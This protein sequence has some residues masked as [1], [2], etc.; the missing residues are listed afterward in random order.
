MLPYD[1]TWKKHRTNAT[2]VASANTSINMFDRVQEAESAHFLLNLL[3][4]P[5]DLHEN[6]RKEAGSVILK[7]IYGYTTKRGK[8][9]LVELANQTMAD[10]AEATVPGKWI[11]DVMPFCKLP[12]NTRVPPFI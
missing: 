2:K 5:N 9:P 8:D 4:S 12:L 7:I 1:E 6:V 11:V 10:F 3:D